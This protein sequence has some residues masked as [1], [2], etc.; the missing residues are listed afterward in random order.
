MVTVNRGSSSAYTNEKL[1][2][3]DVVEPLDHNFVQ[4][5]NQRA[6]IERLEKACKDMIDDVRRSKHA[7]TMT[8]PDML[9]T[10]LDPIFS[11]GLSTLNNLCFGFVPMEAPKGYPPSPAKKQTPNKH[12]KGKRK[13]S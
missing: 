7:K 2:K 10:R 5:E 13:R 3:N 6:R 12:A 4:M 11:P 1:T 9:V 8:I